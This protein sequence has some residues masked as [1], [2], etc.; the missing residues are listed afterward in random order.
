V[1]DAGRKG[2]ENKNFIVLTHQEL[3]DDGSYKIK[4]VGKMLDNKITIEGMFTVVLYAHQEFDKGVTKKM[5]VTNY[6]GRYPAKSP[7]GMFED[8]VILNDLGIVVKKVQEY[9]NG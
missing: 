7:I 5:F 4:T 6:D 1:L 3:D 8:L 2:S 9:Y